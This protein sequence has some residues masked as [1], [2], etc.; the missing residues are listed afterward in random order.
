MMQRT[1][2]LASVTLVLASQAAGQTGTK[3]AAPVVPFA[4]ASIRFER[5]VTD[6][7]AEV[8][9][10]VTGGDEGLAKLTIVSPDGRTVVDFNAPVASTLGMR[11]FLFESPEPGAIEQLKAAY[12]EGVYTFAGTTVTG[13][14][15]RGS[16]ELHHALPPAAAF[17]RPQPD[18]KG[19]PVRST[20]I[21][22]KPAEGALA[23]LVEI[24]ATDEDVSLAA[25]LPGSA[26]QF[27]V[28]EGFLVPGTEYKLAIGAFAKD[29]NATFVETSFTTAAGK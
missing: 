1:G 9:F 15:R 16:A 12:P 22:W 26:T 29:G 19:V 24:E 18:A 3:D 7:D 27:A 5:N 13:G 21:E 17:L 25:K 11:K 14:R 2:F 6:A 10:E 8:V 28:P 4:A 23:Y 20:T